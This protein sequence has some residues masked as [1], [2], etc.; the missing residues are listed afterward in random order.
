MKNSGHAIY[1]TVM[2]SFVLFVA[3]YLFVNG[4]SYYTLKAEDRPFHPAHQELKPSGI[5]G[6]GLGIAGSFFIL[7]GVFSYM[8]R[9]R[10]S[11]FSRLGIL[12]YW[13]EFHIF[14]CT[15]GPV[16]ILYHT[17]FKFGG[18]VAVSFWSMVA[19]FLSGIIG[20]YIYLNIPRTIEGRE[21]SRGEIIE[22]R[23]HILNQ[24]RQDYQADQTII[25]MV[26]KT[27]QT[28]KLEGI[29]LMTRIIK[30][31]RRNRAMLKEIKTELNQQ[32][33]DN[34]TRNKILALC[35]KEFDLNKKLDIL[36]SFQNLFKH[37]HVIHLPFALIM[38]VIM[39]IH[40]AVSI[41]FGYRW[42]F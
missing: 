19:V 9:K 40:V 39:I 14:L 24:L 4:A 37:W 42:I 7:V 11:V 13:L 17:A 20:R 21:L 35:R 25:E 27:L 34:K 18:I 26:S 16:L 23:Y 3:I 33:I 32:N 5:I 28:P 31:N 10:L 29:T 41:T 22:L 30:N 6:H 1:L 12:S 2:T 15:L 8:A 36:S 38:L